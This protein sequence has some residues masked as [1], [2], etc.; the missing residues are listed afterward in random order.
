MSKY[1]EEYT[2]GET[3]ITSG[4]TVTEADVVNFACITGDMHPNHTDAAV[5]EQSHFGKRIAHGLLGLSWAHGFLYRLD[6][7]TDSAIAFLKIEDWNFQ[8]P[9]FFGDTLHAEITVKDIVWSHSKPDRG[10]LKLFF[11]LVKQDGTVCQSGTKWIMMKG[12]RP[13]QEK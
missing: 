13:Q 6:I 2:I 5:M 8:A 11:Q 1:L 10:I 4:R 9:I 3:F 7:I 12:K